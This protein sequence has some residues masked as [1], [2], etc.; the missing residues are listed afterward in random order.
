MIDPRL[1]EILACPL[2]KTEVTLQDDRLV[3]ARC[4]R[5]YPIRDGIPIMLVEEAEPAQPQGQP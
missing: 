5:R 4:H 1:L 2:C 3:C